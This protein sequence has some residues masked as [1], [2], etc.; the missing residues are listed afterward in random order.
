MLITILR[1][2]LPWSRSQ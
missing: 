1:H 2:Q